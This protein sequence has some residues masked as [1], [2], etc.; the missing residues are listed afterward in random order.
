MADGEQNSTQPELLI[1]VDAPSAVNAQSG[2]CCVFDGSSASLDQ[3]MPENAEA[4]PLVLPRIDPDA[5]WTLHGVID[6]YG[7]M[8]GE[9]DLAKLLTVVSGSGGGLGYTIERADFA[10]SSYEVDSEKKIIFIDVDEVFSTRTNKEAADNLREAIFR[11]FENGKTFW[12]H[13]FRVAKGAGITVL[14]AGEIFVGVVGIIVPEPSTTA[15]GLVVTA[16]GAATVTEGVTQMFNV[17]E[18]QGVNPL[19][20][21]FAAVGSWAG[22]ADGEQLARSAFAITNLVVSVG[23]SYK[24]LKLPGK[25]F[26]MRGN[27]RADGRF[28]P[29]GITVGRMQLGYPLEKVGGR[30]LIN[31][32]NN[33]GQWIFRFQQIQGEIVLNGRI[34]NTQNWHR[35]ASVKDMLKVLCKLALHGAKKGL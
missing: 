11:E 10:F 9:E 21:G 35:M 31:V 29:G 2:L 33:S 12:D 8:F 27:Q 4:Q 7:E 32:T 16:F 14:G 23:G 1:S 3:D 15:A 19:E 25:K 17:N 26:L 34:V 30:V 24:L 13:A 5:P 20:E 28:F 22:D 18:G 6:A